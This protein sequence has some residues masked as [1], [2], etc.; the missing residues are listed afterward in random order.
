MA[1]V[2]DVDV[3][4]V[5]TEERFEGAELSKAIAELS[6]MDRSRLFAVIA[7]AGTTNAGIID[8]LSGL[9]A[10]C[11]KENVWF[12]ADAA[13]GGGALA[14][15]SARYLFDGIER[16]NSITIDPH[17]WL[18]APY[19]CG[20]VIYRDI[21]LAKS[22]HS[23]HSAYLDI[24]FKP[25]TTGFNPSDYQIQLT[26]RLRGLPF[27]FSLA[28][29]GT[30]RYAQA[31]ARGIE[32]AQIAGRLINEAGHVELVREP[33]LSCVLYRRTGWT[34]EQYANW[35]FENHK[36]GLCL[37]APTMWQ[38]NGQAEPVAR[39]CFINPDTTEKD[40]S[41]ILETMK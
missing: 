26:R 6:R 19:D 9:A 4:Y 18:F 2:I 30:D 32:L 16:A 39:F 20:A 17:K 33:S 5:P 36:K 13:Y 24:F 41:D 29:H 11:E 15:P 40:I 35:T 27:W 1:K 23:Q 38:K 12:H 10:V 28:M 22:A 3:L 31:V 8:D 34:A 7:T 21:E 25:E 37:V 14:T